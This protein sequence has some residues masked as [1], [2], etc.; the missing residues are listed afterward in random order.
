MVFNLSQVSLVCHP[1]VNINRLLF[2]AFKTE[3]LVTAQRRQLNIVCRPY[4]VTPDPNN[5]KDGSEAE[6]CE[7]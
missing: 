4:H 5:S 2:P 6:E 3:K 7:K 1:L